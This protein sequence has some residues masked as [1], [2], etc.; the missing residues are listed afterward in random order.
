VWDMAHFA[1]LR[2]GGNNCRTLVT[3]RLNAVA[4]SLAMRPAD[5]YKIPILSDEKSLELMRTLTP[6]SVDQHPDEMIEL[7]RD[8]EGLPLALQVAGRLLRAEMSMG[9]G[10]TDLLRELREDARLLAAQ[11]PADRAEGADE[12]PPTIG[13]LLRK[14]TNLL[15]ETHQERFALLGV[16]APKP[17]YFDLDAVTAVWAVDDPRPTVRRLVERGLLEPAGDGRFQIHAL[18]VMHAKSMFGAD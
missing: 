14:S 18:L 4:Q 10:V 5:V 2:V 1:P 16:F 9:W 12:V 7:V 3:S 8:L 15:D 6:Q 13:A 17:A 11:A